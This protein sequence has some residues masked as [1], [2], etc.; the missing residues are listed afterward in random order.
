VRE[1]GRLGVVYAARQIPGSGG[2]PFGADRCLK[3]VSRTAT[4]AVHVF[5]ALSWSDQIRARGSDGILTQSAIKA[6][7]KTSLIR[8]WNP[9]VSSKRDSLV[10]GFSYP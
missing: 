5:S 9:A 6:T 4:F 7:I 3:Q 1:I 10:F 2:F 8:M